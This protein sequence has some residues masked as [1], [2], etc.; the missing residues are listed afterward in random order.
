M[1]LT[2]LN[3]PGHWYA[4]KIYDDH[5]V[6]WSKVWYVWYHL[7]AQRNVTEWHEVKTTEF[8]A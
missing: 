7:D 4:L 5:V 8:K 6:H 2:E 1:S 3:V